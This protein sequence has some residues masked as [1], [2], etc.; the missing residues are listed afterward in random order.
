MLVL[1]GGCSTEKSYFDG[2]RRSRRNPAVTVKVVG[3]GVSP[4]QLVGHAVKLR[5]QA[6]GAF[7]EVW[8]VVDV[9]DFDIDPAV[10]AAASAEVRIAVSNPCFEY[11]LLLH[12][13]DHTAALANYQQVLKCLRK[14]VPDY[15]KTALDFTRY[16]R[17]VEDAV[18]RASAADP[19]IADHRRNPS[20]GVWPLVRSMIPT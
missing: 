14:H 5:D 2:L 11:W 6:P 10:T 9:D 13:T 3:K 19:T 20:S 4:T 16:D 7:D 12:F 15:D 18:R 17:G 1:C 8:C